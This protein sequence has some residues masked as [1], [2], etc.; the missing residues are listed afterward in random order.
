MVQEFKWFRVQG[1]WV[2]GFMGSWDHGLLVQEFWGSGVQLFRGSGCWGFRGFRVLRYR[3]FFQDLE[4]RIMGLGL[5]A[6]GFRFRFCSK[7]IPLFSEV[8]RVLMFIFSP[9]FS[10]TLKKIIYNLTIINNKND[11][12]YYLLNETIVI[13][14]ILVLYRGKNMNETMHSGAF[15][16]SPL[17]TFI[18]IMY[19]YVDKSSGIYTIH[20]VQ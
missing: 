18:G 1:S 2:Y 17:S 20:K 4:F 11:T 13:N 3:I 7:Y 6:E 15:V 5:T 8:C 10:L 12:I 9:G 16:N 19:I 14:A